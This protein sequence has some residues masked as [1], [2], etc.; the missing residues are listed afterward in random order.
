VSGRELSG[1]NGASVAA[2]ETLNCQLR[3]Q[4]EELL[5]REKNSEVL[6]YFINSSGFENAE[7]YLLLVRELFSCT[8]KSLYFVKMVT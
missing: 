5:E 4:D 7:C 3:I 8:I 1:R 6:D 2:S